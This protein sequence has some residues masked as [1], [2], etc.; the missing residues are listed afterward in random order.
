MVHDGVPDKN[1]IDDLARV[2]TGLF[3]ESCRRLIHRFHQSGLEQLFVF[4]RL[5]GESD[6]ADDILAV[7][8]LGIHAACLGQYGSIFQG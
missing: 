2:R 7:R 8:D 1:G 4:F 3:A 5:V 6:P